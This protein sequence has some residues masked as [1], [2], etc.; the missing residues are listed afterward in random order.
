MSG[1]APRTA[2][3]AVRSPSITWTRSRSQ[4]VADLC[5]HHEENLTSAR[6]YRDIPGP[7]PL[8]FL[9]NTWRLLPVLSGLIGR[10][11]LL[12]V[13][14]ADEI[15]RAYRSEGPTPFRPSMPCLV[16]YKSSVRRDFFGDLP[17]VVGVHGD[18]WR[19]FRTRVQRPILQPRT[20]RKYIQPIEEVTSHFINRMC[21]MKDHNQEMPSDFD[22]EIHKWSL[23]CE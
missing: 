4:I 1:V 7:R 11:D 2:I 15:E 17:G 10:P 3:R 20:V 6:P 19:E 21:E 14:D 23:E 22:N 16:H 13:Y 5:P 9:G 18:Q 12:F 8:P